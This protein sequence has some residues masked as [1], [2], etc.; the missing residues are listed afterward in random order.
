MARFRFDPYVQ[1]GQ[2]GATWWLWFVVVI[3]AGILLAAWLGGT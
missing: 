3:V 1:A 2:V